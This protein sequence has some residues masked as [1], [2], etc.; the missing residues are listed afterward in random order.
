ME[1]LWE[2]AA[3]GPDFPVVWR[4]YDRR[5]VDEYVRNLT[6]GGTTGPRPGGP[7]PLFDVVFRGYD[8]RAVERYINGFGR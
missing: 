7:P 4:G 8:R 2:P 6:T 3:Q 1:E 5:Q